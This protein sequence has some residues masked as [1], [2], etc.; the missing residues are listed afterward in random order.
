[1]DRRGIRSGSFFRSIEPLQAFTLPLVEGQVATDGVVYSAV[2]TVG[3]TAI[4]VLNR[5]LDIGIDLE[6]LVLELS[7]TQ[8]F[9][10]LKADSVG[11]INYYWQARQTYIATQAGWAP[12]SPTIS[13]GVPTSGVSGDPSEDTLSGY[14]PVA[15]LP[16]LAGEFQG[17]GLELRL[18]AFGLVPS[19]LVG[20]VKNSSEIRLVG[21][22]IPGA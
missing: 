4:A 1:M 8:R 18:M 3:T 14:Y 21:A 22:V 6:P 12:I 19:G 11:T 16:K 13:K 10:N 9:D 15:S 5:T 20:Q 2:A 7:L 17:R